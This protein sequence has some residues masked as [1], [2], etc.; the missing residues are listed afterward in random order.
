MVLQ[1]REQAMQEYVVHL[2]CVKDRPLCVRE[3]ERY[4]QQV[5][6]RN[7]ADSRPDLRLR[8]DLHKLGLPDLPENLL[9]QQL[10]QHL[11][12]PGLPCPDLLQVVIG[13]C[14]AADPQVAAQAED[15]IKGLMIYHRG[16]C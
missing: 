16:V 8:V 2:L 13:V 15:K 5:A 14:L 12:K 1:V 3:E 9:G 10:G 11:D 7:Q 4:V 6:E